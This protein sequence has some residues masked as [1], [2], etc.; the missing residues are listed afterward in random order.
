MDVNCTKSGGLLRVIMNIIFIVGII[1]VTYS[2]TRNQFDPSIQDN[3]H[4]AV[5]N[6]S[7]SASPTTSH[8]VHLA[9]SPSTIHLT[10]PSSNTIHLAAPSN[11]NTIH[12][13]APPNTIHLVVSPT[14]PATKPYKVK[15]HNVYDPVCLH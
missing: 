11:T 4:I 2:V 10:T 9:T 3:Q 14:P 6:G 1:L 5:T 15:P 13:A 7:H 8:T 12:L